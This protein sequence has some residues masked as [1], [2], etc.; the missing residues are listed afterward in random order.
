MIPL[1]MIVVAFIGAACMAGYA[2]AT[3]AL[4]VMIAMTA[5]RF[6]YATGAG[7]IGA[8]IIGFLA[9]VASFG[10]LAGL[11]FT[12]RSPTLLLVVAIPSAL[13]G[14][15]LVHGVTQDAV[16]SEFWRQAF[17]LTG[18]ACTGLSAL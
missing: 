1:L 7:L 11:F 5:A 3:Y 13:A 12:L 17:C 4:P 9:G 8:G 18:G 2:L 16:L 14:Y 6:A 10:L 15:A